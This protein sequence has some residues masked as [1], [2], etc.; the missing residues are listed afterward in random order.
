MFLVSEKIYEAAGVL[1]VRRCIQ[2]ILQCV[3]HYTCDE[4]NNENMQH[5]VIIIIIFMVRSSSSSSIYTVDCTLQDSISQTQ[6]PPSVFVRVQQQQ[7]QQQEKASDRLRSCWS[8]C[9]AAFLLSVRRWAEGKRQPRQT[10]AHSQS[11]G[12]GPASG[13]RLLQPP[14]P[15][16]EP[17]G[18]AMISGLESLC[19]RC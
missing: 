8:I 6:R 3:Y 15:H 14:T 19:L 4:K 13:E 2:L 18:E 17:H 7:Q 11:G 12:G 10:G 5:V 1:L 9:V 16:A